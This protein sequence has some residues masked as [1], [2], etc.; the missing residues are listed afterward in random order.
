MT[1]IRE[2]LL[3]HHTHTDF[4]YTD[5]PSTTWDL[6]VDY[7]RQAIELCERTADYPDE[8]KF[9]WN[10]EVLWPVQRFLSTAS[11]GEVAR[12]DRAVQA[13]QMDLGAMPFNTGTLLDAEEWSALSR[14]LAPLHSRYRPSVAMQNDINGMS[15]GILPRWIEQG[16]NL[17]WTGPNDYSAAGNPTERPNWWWWEAGDGQR[18]L[19]YL[20]GGYNNGYFYTHESEWRRGPVPSS[21]DVWFNP[22]EPGDVFDFSPS[23]IARAHARCTKRLTELPAVYPFD[24]LPLSVTNMW[25][26]DNDPPLEGLSD[27]VRAWNGAGLEPKLRL[28]TL[29]EVSA[30]AHAAA[31]ST[32]L[33]TLRGDW[34]DWWADYIAPLSTEVSACQ[35]ARRR[36]RDI[37]AT[38][39]QLGVMP[40]V[41]QP[42]VDEAWRDVSVFTEHTFSSF[43]SVAQPYKLS[44]LGHAAEKNGAV[45]R[46][47]ELS[48][49]A[50]TGVL[51]SSSAYR[52]LSASRFIRV[53]NPSEQPRE[54]W[55]SIS[56]AAL[57]FPAT[58]A[59]D[60]ESGEFYP[61]EPFGQEPFW[62][63]PKPGEEPV[64]EVPNDVWPF[65]LTQLRFRPGVLP[66]RTMRTYELIEAPPF[67]P[68]AESLVKLP[69]G[70][71]DPDA[72]FGIGQIVFDIFDA[73]GAR[74]DLLAHSAERLE[75]K[76]RRESPHVLGAS[77]LLSRYGAGTLTRLSHPH[78]YEIE[79]HI[80]IPTGG[81]R[82]ELETTLW[83]KE[84]TVPQAIYLAL[85]VA[86]QKPTIWYDS[87]GQPTR[88]GYD[89]LPNT[90]GEYLTVGA[91]VTIEMQDRRVVVATPDTPLCCFDSPAARS[92]RRTFTPQT[93]TILALL[94][95][96]FWMTNT[97]ITKAAKLR[98]RHVVEWFAA[99]AAP[100]PLAV[101]G[102]LY[103]MPCAEAE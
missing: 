67:A 20:A 14:D 80:F 17:Y 9:R 82:V 37:P 53:V 11:A 29:R 70:L 51:R 52:P 92:G 93:G 34:P 90:C 15:W 1:P 50:M 3:V 48:R 99:G 43:D 38:S 103:A 78:C 76:V 56:S 31:K 97:P 71:F 42:K 35:A 45:Y 57:R 64:V 63:A 69:A 41:Y 28:A 58:A 49:S 85:P 21:S 13:G 83:L 91:G 36:L 33:P 19:V 55:V 87:L 72:E 84:N 54:G 32:S 39:S 102:D 73:F 46:A 98:V 16:V 23:G 95:H 24:F 77:P 100:D 47:E 26:Y 18:L 101:G 30:A 89:Q 79:Q 44:A 96:N 62:G 40:S 22:P 94:H 81:R 60:V 5:L 68:L 12:F 65:R 59:R 27:F 6:H 4:G 7:I 88:V 10:C 86:G 8:A 66:A 61:L 25:R 2:L 75:G 74:E